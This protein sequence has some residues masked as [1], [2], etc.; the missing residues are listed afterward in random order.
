MLVVCLYV[1]DL[2]FMGNDEV[3]ID[4]FKASMMAEFDDRF[5]SD[6]LFSCP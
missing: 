6:V 1:D 2:I 4:T 5:G 3:M